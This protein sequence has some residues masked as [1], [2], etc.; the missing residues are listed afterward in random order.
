MSKRRVVITGLGCVT[1]SGESA[2]DMFNSLCEGASGVSLIECFD[3]KNFSVKIAGEIKHFDIK[4]Y[5]GH[6]V[7]KRLDRFA[8]FA[9]A[10]GIQAVTDSGLDFDKENRDR[11]GV[12]DVVCTFSFW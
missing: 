10:S 11:V 7:G 9:L 4:K 3:T 6:R 5:V 12:S 1:A 2:E 8:Q